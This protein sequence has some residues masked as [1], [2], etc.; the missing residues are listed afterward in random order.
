MRKDELEIERAYNTILELIELS[1]EPGRVVLLFGD[2][3]GNNDYIHYQL[4]PSDLSDE[5]GR[6]K[7]AK[8]LNLIAAR[9][10]LCT[11]WT[12]LMYDCATQEAAYHPELIGQVF[13]VHVVQR[14]MRNGKVYKDVDQ[15]YSTPLMNDEI[16]LFQKRRSES[17]IENAKRVW[18]IKEAECKNRI[19]EEKKEQ[20]RLKKV[21]AEYWAAK[22]KSLREEIKSGKRKFTLNLK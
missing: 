1:S 6:K 3:N 2:K 21:E 20:E 11:N 8:Y 10:Q 18:K 4:N 14:R 17:L 15:I 16:I 13:P 5:K 9:S 7:A 12:N 22:N 19:K